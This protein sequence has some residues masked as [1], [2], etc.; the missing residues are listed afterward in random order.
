LSPIVPKGRGKSIDKDLN[1]D[2]E[3]SEQNFESLQLLHH[4]L[5]G[6]QF[7]QHKLTLPRRLISASAIESTSK[8]EEDAI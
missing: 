5:D 2:D 3:D 7:M 8:N 4:C 1:I 6:Y